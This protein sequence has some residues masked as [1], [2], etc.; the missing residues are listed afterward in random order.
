LAVI[1]S[2]LAIEGIASEILAAGAAVRRGAPV[3]GQNGKAT[4]AHGPA[5]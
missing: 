5:R 3:F 2:N 4:T 1:A